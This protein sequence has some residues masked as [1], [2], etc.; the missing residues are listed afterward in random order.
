VL[1]WSTGN[2]LATTTKELRLTVDPLPADEPTS[3][4][5][6]TEAEIIEGSR[7]PPAVRQWR[8]D[9]ILRW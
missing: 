9:A 3:C 4:S 6:P 8:A 1:T 7:I 2:R 5:Q